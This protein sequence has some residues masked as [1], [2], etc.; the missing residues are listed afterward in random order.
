MKASPST[1]TQTVIMRE[2]SIA[3]K[4]FWTIFMWFSSRNLVWLFDYVLWREVVLR[5]FSFQIS[6]FFQGGRPL[7]LGRTT[8]T[9]NTGVLSCNWSL[10]YISLNWLVLHFGAFSFQEIDWCYS[11]FLISGNWLQEADWEADG[12]PKLIHALQRRFSQSEFLWFTSSQARSLAWKL[13]FLQAWFLISSYLPSSQKSLIFLS[14]LPVSPFTLL[15]S[16]FLLFGSIR[17]L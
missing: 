10:F 14:T 2:N 1:P 7:A 15:I 13:D 16:S 9:L 11:A 6:Y 12:R 17:F 4:H 5:N 8:R 3:A